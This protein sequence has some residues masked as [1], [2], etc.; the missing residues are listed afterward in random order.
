MRQRLTCV[1]G[2]ALL[3]TLAAGAAEFWEKKDYRQ[4]SEKD[5]RKM[6]TDSPWARQYML[7]SVHITPLQVEPTDPPEGAGPG[8]LSGGPPDNPGTRERHENPRIIYQVQFRSA[9]PVRQAMVRLQ[10]L[11]VNYDK[12]SEA[13]KQ[14]F[15]QQA[16]AFLRADVSNVVVLNVQYA[17]NLLQDA[18]DLDRYWKTQTT[19]TLRN[20][21]FLI[22][23]E[24]QQA[25]LMQYVAA[26]GSSPVFQLAFPRL[27]E[28]EP[29]VGPSDKSLQLEFVHPD[30]R[31]QGEQRVLVEFK[32]K[33]MLVGGEVVF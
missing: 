25:Q 18:L 20:R 7:S 11:Q 31:G 21:T 14:N 23:G 28:G 1:L 24:G 8:G 2:L 12:L 6:L 30:V 22:G 9:L 17:S 27:V 4:W 33:K 15:D 3:A 10:Q 29:L 32:V 5:C 13:E 26:E 16:E 19:E